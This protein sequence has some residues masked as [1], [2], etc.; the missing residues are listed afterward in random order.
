MTARE[1]SRRN[2]EW[3]KDSPSSASRVPSSCTSFPPS[4]FSFPLRQEW[5]R[6]WMTSHWLIISW[7]ISP[8]YSTEQLSK[9]RH[10]RRSS[11]SF[12]FPSSF[13]RAS[14]HLSRRLGNI[15][16]SPTY[17]FSTVF[18][19]F[20]LLLLVSSSLPSLLS[21]DWHSMTAGIRWR[22][23]SFSSASK[24]KIKWTRQRIQSRYEIWMAIFLYKPVAVR[25]GSLL[26]DISAYVMY[27]SREKKYRK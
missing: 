5:E 3:L 17:F 8:R 20:L 2:S 11:A 16:W 27:R 25:R 12:Y 13:Y 22:S 24:R 15:D 10:C 18:Y 7:S 23:F 26:F 4:F 19:F 9:G 21:R 14:V 6:T 1:G